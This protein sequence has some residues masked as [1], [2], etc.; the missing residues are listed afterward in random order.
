MDNYI[1]FSDVKATT[2]SGFKRRQPRQQIICIEL[3]NSTF[4]GNNVDTNSIILAATNLALVAI[5]SPQ[6]VYF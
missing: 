6:I 4:G 2:T 5:M 3:P 1:N